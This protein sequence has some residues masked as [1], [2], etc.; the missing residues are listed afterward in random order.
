MSPVVILYVEDEESD[1]VLL[2]Q[3]SFWVRPAV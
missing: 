2:Q 3:F 1:V